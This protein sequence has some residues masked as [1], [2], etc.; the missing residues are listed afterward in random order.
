MRT[1]AAQPITRAL[2]KIVGHDRSTCT[3]GCGAGLTGTYGLDRRARHRTVGAEHAT[4]ARLRPQPCAATG[5]LVKELAGI[6][7]HGLGFCGSAIRTGDN[8]FKDHGIPYSM[9][10]ISEAPVG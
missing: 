8:G 10:P 5:A 3:A 9:E 6:S 1:R 2:H 4:I 7:R